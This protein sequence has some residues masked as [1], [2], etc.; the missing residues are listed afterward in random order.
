M[1]AGRAPNF[2]PAQTSQ[3]ANQNVPS[4]IKVEVEIVGEGL[5]LNAEVRRGSIESVGQVV[6]QY[7][8]GQTRKTA[9]DAVETFY[10]PG[11]SIAGSG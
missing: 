10:E 11:G 8:E 2:N 9:M 5:N 6:P 1:N 7:D 3:A 4:K